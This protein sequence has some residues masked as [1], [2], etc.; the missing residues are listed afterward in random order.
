MIT[1]AELNRRALGQEE[2]HTIQSFDDLLKDDEYMRLWEEDFE[3]RMREN[4]DADDTPEI[5]FQ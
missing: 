1:Q 5:P 2:K 3:R 4:P